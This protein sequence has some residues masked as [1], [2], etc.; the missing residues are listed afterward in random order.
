MSILVIGGSNIDLIGTSE[1]VF[2]AFDSN[3]G[4]FYTAHGGVGRN[5]VENLAR[6]KHD[7]TFITVLGNDTYGAAIKKR[8][9]NRV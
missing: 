7:V 6:L 2:N 1:G 9:I 3:P 5:V 8:R 4:E